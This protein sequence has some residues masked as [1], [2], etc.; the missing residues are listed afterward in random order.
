[1]D[2]SAFG[3]IDDTAIDAWTGA[4]WPVCNGWVDLGE[5]PAHGC[6]VLCLRDA[7]PRPG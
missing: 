7:P 2:V 6:V 5:L 3:V 4:H 1:V